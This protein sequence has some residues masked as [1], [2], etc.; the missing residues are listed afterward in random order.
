M[1]SISGQNAESPPQGR[2]VETIRIGCAGWSVPRVDTDSFTVARSQLQRYAVRFD[3]VEINS[4]FYRMHKSATYARWAASVPAGFRFSVKMP[5]TITHEQRLADSGTLL[6]EFF[7]DI[8]ALGDRLGCVL[9][10]LPP[11]LPFDRSRMQDFLAEL[12]QH[13]SGDVAIEP[14]HP[15]WFNA[16]AERLLVDHGIA[17]VAADPAVVAAAALPGGATQ[18]VYFRL[19][20]TPHMYYSSYAQD[21]LV[22]LGKQLRRAAAAGARAWCIFDNT[23]RGAAIPNALAL[24]RLLQTSW[25]ETLSQDLP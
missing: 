14:R 2:P 17:R 21:D 3:C 19:H 9:I 23:A 8:G 11:S 6:N 22:A 1:V 20:G 7:T 4:S 15:T 10:Q 18:L 16:R 5:R 24:Q 25:R 12:R 13:C